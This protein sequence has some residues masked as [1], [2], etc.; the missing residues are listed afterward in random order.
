MKKYIYTTLFLLGSFSAYAQNNDDIEEVEVKGK[1]LYVDQVNSL[2]P[3][4]PI[5]DVPQSVSVITDEEIKDQGFREIGDIIRYMPGVN[6]SQGEGHRDAVVFRGVRSTADFYQDGVRDD[7]QYYRSLYNVEQLEILRGP[8]ALLFGRGGTGGLINRVSK[9]AEIGEAFGSIDFGAD[10][11]GAAD[12]AVDANFATSDST[13]VRLNLHTD[14]L[15]NHRDFY[16]GERYG[17]NPTVKIQ[18]DDA[19][20]ID[21]SYEYADHERFID[22][23]I[24]T[25][26]NKPVESLKDVVFGVEGLN[27]QTLEA[28]ILRGSLAHD[29]SDTGKFN[30]SITSSDF[31]K[32]YKNLYAA[33]YD[34]DANTVKLDGYLDPTERQNLIVSANVVNEFSNGSTSGTILVGLEFVDTDNKNYRYNTF[35]NNRAGKDAGEPTDQQ[36]FNIT[37]PLNIAKT[38][39]GLD[40]TVDYTTDLKS[41]S[42]SDLTVTSFYLQGDIDFSDSW[43]MIIGGRLDNFDITVTD[44][45]KSQDQ[46][47]KDDMFSPRL[48]VIYKPADNMSLYVSYSES[49]L[50]R[51]G[52]QYKKLDASGAALD[53]DVYKNTEFGY[54]YDINDALTF[55]AAIFDSESTRAEKD[56]ETGEMNEIRGL[57]VEGYE[58]ELSGD[59]DDQNNL[60][61]GYTSLDGVTSKGTKQPRE[62]PNQMLSLWYSYQA[63]ETFG[64][65]LGVTHQAESFIK[66]TTN[67]STG[68]ALPDYTR[69]D[70]ALHINA[71]DNDV[72]RVHIE[73]LTDELYFPHSHSTHQASVGE[74]LSARV[75]YSRRF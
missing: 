27:L 49:F 45:K 62:L 42:E 40:S 47:R 59:I 41:S 43:K 35:F 44:V 7:V 17:I 55:T 12:L 53:P 50:P 3:P 24:P 22:R 65:G 48:G 39:I 14:S 37:R 11:F 29:Y 36:I 54:K 71:S 8:N 2:K 61:F 73:N 74:S 60:T 1:V 13:A 72:V 64:F 32:M 15:A 51:S 57:E 46:S 58:L 56:N 66:D 68:P 69:V 63:N 33:G 6:T 5:L 70:F 19:T 34:A 30:M 23:G 28:S 21:L 10:S 4:V 9:K 75:S 38:S 25:A 67:G 31:K 20:T 52:E 26:N 18:V 16:E